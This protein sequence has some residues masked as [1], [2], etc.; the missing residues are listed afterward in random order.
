MVLKSAAD[1]TKGTSLM[2]HSEELLQ[3]IRTDRVPNKDQILAARKL[4]GQITE[5]I[6][7]ANERAAAQRSLN[8][9][10]LNFQLA[11]LSDDPVLMEKCR[12][13]FEALVKKVGTTAQKA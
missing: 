10:Y 5:T 7:C 3:S 13:D 11:V 9:A 1:Q 2:T 4:A 6:S 8:D 12:R